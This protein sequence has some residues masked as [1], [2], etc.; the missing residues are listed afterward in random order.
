MPPASDSAVLRAHAQQ[1]WYAGLEAVRSDHLM[2]AAMRVDGHWLL[3]GD[4]AIDLGA[5]GRVAVVGA[6]KAGAGMAAELEAILGDR[7]PTTFAL[8]SYPAA[9]R[10]CCRRL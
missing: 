6:G 9:V 5:V 4:R 2:R 7:L 3:I 8:R 10:R 1:I